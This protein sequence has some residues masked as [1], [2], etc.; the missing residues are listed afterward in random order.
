MLL[1][2]HIYQ[3]KSSGT[4]HERLKTKYLS[5]APKESE[6]KYFWRQYYD[7]TEEIVREDTLSYDKTGNLISRM[8]FDYR[9]STSQSEHQIGT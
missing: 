7:I 4:D 5:Y 8:L 3:Y 6:S 1:D 9:G 2:E